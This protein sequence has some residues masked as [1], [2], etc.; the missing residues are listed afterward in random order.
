MPA[1]R[2]ARIG[3]MPS[4]SGGLARLACTRLRERGIPVLPL[5]SK[6]GLGIEQID[7]PAARIKVRSQIKLVQLAADALQD[8]LLGFIWHATM[9]FAKR[10]A[11]LRAG[12]LRGP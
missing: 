9:T 1:S 5:L 8:D 4:A 10:P 11:L 12:I 2:P 7:D 6:A 3:S